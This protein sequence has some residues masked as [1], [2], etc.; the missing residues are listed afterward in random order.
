M[1]LSTRSLVV[2]FAALI[3]GIAA[4]SIAVVPAETSE[5]ATM[6]LWLAARAA[7]FVA[8][9]L[10]TAEV[11]IGLLMSHPENPTRWKLSKTVFPWH[12]N[13]TVFTFAFVG[14][15]VAS[16]AADPYAGVGI[17]GALIPG[18]SEYR[19]VP[20][21]LGVL[22]AYAAVIV[23]ATARFTSIL[24]RGVWLK[25][26]R[27]SL[28]VWAL[29][30]LHGVYAGTDTLAT[31]GLYLGSGLLLVLLASY[32]YWVNRPARRAPVPATP[33]TAISALTP[34]SAPASAPIPEGALR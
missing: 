21:A 17:G 28:G 16:L 9:I 20:V 29:A 1:R 4:S 13:L 11:A 18:L 27:L 6:R 5:E 15:H 14:V 10:L 34:T 25:I 30:W 7:G 31:G 8:F 19:S 2:L 24:P 22:A 32:R 3:V 12:E 26:H 23:A 33:A